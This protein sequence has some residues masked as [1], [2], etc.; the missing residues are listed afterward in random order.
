MFWAQI[1]SGFRNW[2]SEIKTASAEIKDNFKHAYHREEAALLWRRNLYL[3]KVLRF[4][5][6]GVTSLHLYDSCLSFRKARTCIRGVV[7][8]PGAWQRGTSWTNAPA[9]VCDTLGYILLTFPSALGRKTKVVFFEIST[10]PAR[11]THHASLH[12]AFKMLQTCRAEERPFPKALVVETP[13]AAKISTLSSHLQQGTGRIYLETLN[14][15]QCTELCSCSGSCVW[16]NQVAIQQF[17][18]PQ[19]PKY[20]VYLLR[21]HSWVKSGWSV[22]EKGWG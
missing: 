2:A 1:T 20:S 18:W 17:C 11:L 5:S 14:L 12:S 4:D 8:L 6:D 21:K 22:R 7:L 3:W 10:P 15:W 19:I 16:Y 13:S 9:G